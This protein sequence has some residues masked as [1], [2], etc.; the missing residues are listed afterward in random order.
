[1]LRLQSKLDLARSFDRQT[2]A[3]LPALPH[4]MAKQV[5]RSEIEKGC[6]MGSMEPSQEGKPVA[7]KDLPRSSPRTSSGPLWWTTPQE[8]Q[9]GQTDSFMQGHSGTLGHVTGSHEDTV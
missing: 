8:R 7:S 2:S 4:T 6:H 5:A 3:D 9:E 1:M